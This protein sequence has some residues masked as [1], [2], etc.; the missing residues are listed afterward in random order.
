MGERKKREGENRGLNGRGGEGG[1]R[2][3]RARERERKSDDEELRACVGGKRR[4]AQAV[5]TRYNRYCD[6]FDR[7]PYFF[8]VV[9]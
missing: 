9:P 4:V 1:D 7:T 5:V 2:E 8:P 6:I 3:R